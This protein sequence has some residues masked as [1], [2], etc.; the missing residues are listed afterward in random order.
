VA[1]AAA[2]VGAERASA[3]VTTIPAA[4]LAG[5]AVITEPPTPLAT[6]RRSWL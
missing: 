1:A 4:I 6:R 3:M 5:Q 2:L